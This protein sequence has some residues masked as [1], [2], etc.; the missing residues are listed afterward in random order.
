MKII[1][2]FIVD[3]DRYEFDFK[4]CTVRK[5]YAQVDTSQDAPYYGTWASPE[6]LQIVS[7]TEGDV[8]VTNCESPQ[9]FHDQIRE[10]K[11]WNEDYGYRFI[12]IDPACN[13]N[14]IAWFQ[15]CCL[16]DLLH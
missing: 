14:L 6:K 2:D 16:G 7:Y 1:R 11:K 9:E 3:G 4:L 13:P 12:G 8:T 5:G 15:A 10:M